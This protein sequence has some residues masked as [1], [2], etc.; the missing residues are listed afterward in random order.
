VGGVC[1]VLLALVAVPLGARLVGVDDRAV[2]LVLGAALA[3]CAAVAA[4]FATVGLTAVGS[5]AGVL[6]G[7]AIALGHLAWLWPLWTA[8]PTG[9]AARPF[10]VVTGNALY[11]NAD[12]RGLARDLLGAAPDVLAVQELNP[13]LAD[14]LAGAFPF[15]RTLPQR[16]S[17]GIGVWSRLPVKDLRTRDLA[18]A[19]A[20]RVVLDTGAGPPTTL[21][22]VHAEGPV[23]A[24]GR[25]RWSAQLT[26]L[27]RHLSRESAG[28]V[29]VV[30]DFNATA[31]NSPFAAV[32]RTGLEDAAVRVGR[33]F[34]MTWPVGYGPL[35]P[36]LRL[37]H[38][39]VS[40]DVSVLS[41]RTAAGHGSDHRFLVARLAVARP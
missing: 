8:G 24:E 23:S 5:R 29:V 18:G 6:T 10:T 27:R 1:W 19:P 7:I 21:W 3:P 20:L 13:T 38:V 28:P 11:T 25:R 14:E 41:M 26:S 12:G 4:V 32:L 31:A 17:Q 35:P 2:A 15:S 36:V 40:R 16:N 37:D 39:L 34:D 30:G 9:E 33:P 22:V